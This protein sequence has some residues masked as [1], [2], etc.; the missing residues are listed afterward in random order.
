MEVLELQKI[1]GDERGISTT[2]ANLGNLHADSGEWERARAYY[3]EA[4]DLMNEVGDHAAKAVLLSDLG[5]VARETAQFDQ[6]LEYYQ[7][8]IVLMRRVGNQAGQADV[9]RM[10]ARLYLAQCRYDEALACTQTSFAIAERL[11]DEL[12]MGGAWYVHGELLRS[13]RGVGRHHTLSGSRRP[14]RS[15][16]SIAKNL[17]KIGSG[18]VPFKR[19]WPKLRKRTANE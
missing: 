19:E 10:M 8:S 18:F 11:H 12:R 16:I 9:Y 4:L 17:K 1:L 2:L 15:K 6:A 13:Q 7:E 14:Y 5:L 3:L